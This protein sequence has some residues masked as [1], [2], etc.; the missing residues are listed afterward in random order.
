MV[1]LARVRDQGRGSAMSTKDWYVSRSFRV[2][3]AL[4]FCT[5]ASVSPAGTVILCP[6]QVCPH[7]VGYFRDTHQKTR[8]FCPARGRSARSLSSCLPAA[9]RPF[10]LYRRASVSF[11][12]GRTSKRL[13]G[14][15]IYYVDQVIVYMF[16]AW[17]THSKNLFA[18]P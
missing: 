13:R 2:A 1:R 12:Q 7:F 18:E 6:E 14:V 17:T 5:A 15:S 3:T 11:R 8:Y 10:R 16:L 9:G 4:L